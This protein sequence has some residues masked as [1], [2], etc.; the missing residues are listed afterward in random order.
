MVLQENNFNS[1]AKSKSLNTFLKEVSTSS[2]KKQTYTGFLNNKMLV[3]K[4][5]KTGVPINL[6]LEIVQS[7][8]FSEAQ[9]ANFLEINIRTLQRY[10]NDKK[11]VFKKLQSE[12]IFEL[13]EIVNFAHQVFD[14]MEHFKMWLNTPSIPLNKVKPIDLLDNSF[15]IDLVMGQLIRI[16]HGIFI[17]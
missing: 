17:L 15:G 13:A 1:F 14:E 6:F 5:V 12:K 2:K 8:P 11:L 10:K 7:S 3:A 16:E 4:A 9:W